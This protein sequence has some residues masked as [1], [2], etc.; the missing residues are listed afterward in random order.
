M[1]I[2]KK[3][4]AGPE[5]FEVACML[6]RAGIRS[7]NPSFNEEQITEELQRRLDIGHRLEYRRLRP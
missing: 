3:L 5:L 6:A 7:Q 1:S 2:A 4:A